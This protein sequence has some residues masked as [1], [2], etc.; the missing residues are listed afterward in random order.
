ML[1]LT[2][3]GCFDGEFV[4]VLQS[5][6]PPETSIQTSNDSPIAICPSGN[7]NSC[8]SEDIGSALYSSDGLSF[9]SHSANVSDLNGT[10]IFNSFHN[11]LPHH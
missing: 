7:S 11:F 9:P 10:I 5:E 4:K 2:S 6:N 3:S 8:P 1:K